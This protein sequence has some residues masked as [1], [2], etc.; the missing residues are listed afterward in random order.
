LTRERLEVDDADWHWFWNDD[1]VGKIRIRGENA[2]GET[3]LFIGI[4]PEVA[5]DEYLGPV[6]HADVEDIELDPFR[7][8]Y[9]PAAGGPPRQPPTAQDFWAASTS[10]VGTQTLTWKIRDGNWSVVV[11]NADGSR[12]VAADVDL[13][14]KL[15]FLL[16]LAIGLLVGGAL[17]LA[18]SIALAVFAAREPR[19]PATPPAPAG[20]SPPA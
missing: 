2:A 8:E 1:W 13:G 17:V 6:A 10:G 5:V 18:G 19:P 4:G 16:W 12:R 14:A 9:R 20:E 15:S 3:P 11:M 7:V